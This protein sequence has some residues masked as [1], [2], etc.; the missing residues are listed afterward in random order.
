EKPP[1]HL[2][3]GFREF[4][5]GF[6]YGRVVE[7]SNEEDE[8]WTIGRVCLWPNALYTGL[9]FSWRVPI[10]RERTLAVDWAYT[11]VPA[12]KL[13]FHQERIPYSYLPLQAT[14]GRWLV[15]DI[16]HQ[17]LVALVAQGPIADRTAEH[18]GASDEGIILMRRKF[19][20]EMKR[21]AQGCAEPF[22]L[23]VQDEV[24]DLPFMGR[25]YLLE[26]RPTE[27]KG[28]DAVQRQVFQE[29]VISG[30]SEETL[31]AWTEVFGEPPAFHCEID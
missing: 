2:K 26:N 16:V 30:L 27:K 25:D 15:G 6:Q 3:I 22:A 7:G 12:E 8:A 9:N 17:D 28:F 11:P 29:H 1:K 13:P 31:Q 20:S 4:D 19:F 24:C 10:D 14:D 21:Q 5:Y 23:P 18:L